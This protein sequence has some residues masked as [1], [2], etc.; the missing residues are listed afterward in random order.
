MLC[1]IQQFLALSS[2][3]ELNQSMWQLLSTGCLDGKKPKSSSQ[4]GIQ[5]RNGATRPWNGSTWVPAIAEQPTVPQYFPWIVTFEIFFFSNYTIFFFKVPT[6]MC[7]TYCFTIW[8]L[9]HLPEIITRW[10]TRILLQ[11]KFYA[12]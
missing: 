3:K 8:L 1:L 12:I 4:S 5:I 7:M 10:L 6:S 11:S 2:N 9:F